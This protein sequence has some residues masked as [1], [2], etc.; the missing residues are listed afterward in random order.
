MDEELHRLIRNAKQGDQEEFAALVRRFKD[1]VYRYAYGMLGDTM[2]AEDVAQEVFVK[3]YGS[4]SK[5]ESEFAFVSWL[6]R[7]VFNLCADR[8]KKAKQGKDVRGFGIGV[9][10][11]GSK[12]GA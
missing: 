11:H 4:L 12:G 5:L 8:L 1:H 9:G 2:E 7:I 6:N 10:R 3:C